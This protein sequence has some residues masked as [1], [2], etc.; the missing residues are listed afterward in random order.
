MQ[1]CCFY[2]YTAGCASGIHGG[3]YVRT[4]VSWYAVHTLLGTNQTGC[5]HKA[6]VCIHCCSVA[7]IYYAITYTLLYI[8]SV[9]RLVSHCKWCHLLSLPF[10]RV[11]HVTVPLDLAIHS[12]AV[13][14]KSSLV[15]YCCVTCPFSVHMEGV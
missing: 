9:Q 15:T 4:V 10:S 12:L 2:H 13:K 3:R 5:T 1:W 14:V 7:D 6:T 8:H 11:W